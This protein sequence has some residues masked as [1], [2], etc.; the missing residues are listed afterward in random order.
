MAKSYTDV[1][2]TWPMS[3]RAVGNSG[4]RGGQVSCESPLFLIE[5]SPSGFQVQVVQIIVSEP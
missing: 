4:G 3:N 5:T 1:C 2:P